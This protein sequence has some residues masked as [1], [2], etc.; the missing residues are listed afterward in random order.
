MQ[1]HRAHV[2]FEQQVLR[3]AASAA[4]RAANESRTRLNVD[5]PSQSTLV[6][7]ESMDAATHDMG[8]DAAARGL[9]FRKFRHGLA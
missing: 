3:P 4:N 8:F 7:D 6:D 2:G 5:G 9:D 1:D